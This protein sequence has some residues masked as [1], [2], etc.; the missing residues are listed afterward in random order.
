MY[1]E[2]LE[3][4]TKAQKSKLPSGFCLGEAASSTDEERHQFSFPP[5]MVFQR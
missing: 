3:Q 1:P 2:Q 5:V 4:A